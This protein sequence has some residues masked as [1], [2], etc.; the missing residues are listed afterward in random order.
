MS[1]Q[2]VN[3]QHGFRQN[4]SILTNLALYQSK[5]ILDFNDRQQIDSIL[6][7]FQKAFDKVNNRF[8]SAK[9]EHF[10]FNS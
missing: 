4:K 7:N 3:N 8:L 5:V 10:G 1:Q 9:L 6:T 2:L